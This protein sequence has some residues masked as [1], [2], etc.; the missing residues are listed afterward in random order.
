MGIQWIIL[1]FLI[2]AVWLSRGTLGRSR[3][4]LYAAMH[5]GT[6]VC[7]TCG[8]PADPRATDRCAECGET[9]AHA[10]TLTP[11]LALRM[12]PP[13]PLLAASILIGAVIIGTMVASAVGTA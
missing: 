11:A 10:G 2:A 1:I 9:Y 4:R 8:Y 3:K 6:P 7:G 5:K 12:G 13:F